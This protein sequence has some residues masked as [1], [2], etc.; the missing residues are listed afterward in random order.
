MKVREFE[1]GSLEQQSNYLGQRIGLKSLSLKPHVGYQMQ[2]NKAWQ[3]GIQIQTQLL[4][5]IDLTQFAG[6]ARKFPL[7]GQLTIRK[8]LY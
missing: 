3:V 8:T 1:N 5:Q 2:V 4:D 7:I 6:E